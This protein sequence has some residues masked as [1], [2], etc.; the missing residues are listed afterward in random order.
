MF[1]TWFYDCAIIFRA[2]TLMKARLK[3]AQKGHSLLRKKSDALTIKFRGIL[4]KIIEV[5]FDF[6]IVWKWGST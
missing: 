5:N 4:R 3:G 6:C 1:K 2:L